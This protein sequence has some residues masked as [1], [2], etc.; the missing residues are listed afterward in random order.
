MRL[1]IPSYRAEIP[2]N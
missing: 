2:S 1:L